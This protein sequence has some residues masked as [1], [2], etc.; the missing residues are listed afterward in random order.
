MESHPDELKTLPPSSGEPK[1]R[2]ER[3]APAVPRIRSFRIEQL[4]ERIA[5]AVDAF[6]W[7]EPIP[8]AH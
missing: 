5:P 4:E 6:I 7:I 8:S 2:E 1:K 3:I